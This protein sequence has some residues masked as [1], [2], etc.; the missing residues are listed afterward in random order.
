[1]LILLLLIGIMLIIFNIKAIKKEEKSFDRAFKNA[2]LSTDEIDVK[3]G[4][5][6]KEFSETILE[7]Q[8]EILELKE[9]Y[10]IK[11]KEKEYDNIV[12]KN[13]EISNVP[14]IEKIDEE[15][16][17]IN[18]EEIEKIGEAKEKTL[19]N[20]IKIQQIKELFEKDLTI[21]EIVE[22]SGLGKGEIL[23]IKELYIK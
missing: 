14:I 3:M 19:E 12:G 9:K 8:Q 7:L 18:L 20:N 17:K 15:E 5:L 2:E 10:D 23:L 22:K 13:L 4:E 16:S 1:M 6:R 11:Y 21:D